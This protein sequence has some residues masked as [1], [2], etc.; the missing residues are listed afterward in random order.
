MLI[1]IIQ[2]TGN[3]PIVLLGSGTS[4]VGDPSGKDK[5]RQLLEDH[6]LQKNSISIKKKYRKVFYKRFKIPQNKVYR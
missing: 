2:K 4:K 6:E 3:Q 5:A 1:R